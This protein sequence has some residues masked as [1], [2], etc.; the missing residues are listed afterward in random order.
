MSLFRELKQ[1]NV[2][3]VGAAYVVAAW[4]LIQVAE[5]IFPLFGFDDTPARIVVIVLAIG[6]IPALVFAWAFEFT[7]E[8]LKKESHPVHRPANGQETQYP[9]SC[10]DGARDHVFCSR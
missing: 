10:R 4:L 6:L 2:L 1:R 7:P 9:D 5:T 3:R 8:G